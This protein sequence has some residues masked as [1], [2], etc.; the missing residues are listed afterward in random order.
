MYRKNDVEG[1]EKK[2]FSLSQLLMDPLTV[3]EKYTQIVGNI[4]KV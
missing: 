3:I 2:D 1:E 4:Q